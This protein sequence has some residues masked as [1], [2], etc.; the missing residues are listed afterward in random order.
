MQRFTI[1]IAFTLLAQV[2]C[3]RGLHPNADVE[4]ADNALR[5]GLDAWKSGQSLEDLEKGTS[6]IMNEDDWR[7]GKKLLDF[8]MD[9]GALS[10]RQVRCKVRIKLQ[11]KDG[12][13]TER[14]AFYIIDTTPRIVIV[15]DSFASLTQ[16]EDRVALANSIHAIRLEA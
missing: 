14:D 1:V 16:R 9:K 8:K 15:R 10:G 6:I 11:G 12:K 5:T 3:S 7:T 13:T 2:G 4:A